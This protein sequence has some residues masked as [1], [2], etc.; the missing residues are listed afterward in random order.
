VRFGLA[1]SIAIALAC[2]LL[3]VSGAVLRQYQIGRAAYRAS[4][5]ALNMGDQRSAIAEARLA[6][7]TLAP[8]SPYPALGFERLRFIAKDA[9]ARG[10]RS[11]ERAAWIALAGA[12]QVS[13][14][15]NE[16][17]L[18]AEAR[19]HLES[20]DGP[21]SWTNHRATEHGQ[22]TWAISFAG[23]LALACIWF[24]FGPRFAK[25]R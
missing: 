18:T 7:A 15:D 21:G 13:M 20:L 19:A 1:K 9:V 16:A 5:A 6:A 25:A 17:R 22:G 24:A 8:G 3:I 12:A 11:Q 2:L 23:V 14:G 10:D 4:I